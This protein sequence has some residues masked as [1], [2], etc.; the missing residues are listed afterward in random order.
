LLNRC[1]LLFMFLCPFIINILWA[2]FTYEVFLGI[3]LGYMNDPDLCLSK[4]CN[5]YR[6]INELT[7]FFSFIYCHKYVFHFT[8]SWLINKIKQNTYQFKIWSMLICDTM[9]S[10]LVKHFQKCLL[11]HYNYL[12]GKSC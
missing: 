2:G 6:L 10:C 12:L 3:G 1:S 5:F 7:C 11:L 4:L 9:Q 8:K